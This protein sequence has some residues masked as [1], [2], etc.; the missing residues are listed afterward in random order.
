MIPTVY[1]LFFPH[2]DKDVT[3]ATNHIVDL[4]GRLREME[5][6]LKESHSREARVLR[7]V[8]EHKRRYREA[9]H[10]NTRLKGTGARVH[11]SE[12]QYTTK[13]L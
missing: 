7:E 9:R 3:E 6:S 11:G 5:G 1:N 10:E 12:I 8:E 2:Q 13:V 4:S